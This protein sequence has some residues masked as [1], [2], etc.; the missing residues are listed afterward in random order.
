MT[1]KKDIRI[2]SNV[3]DDI[4]LKAPNRA[5]MRAVGFTDESFKKPQIGVVSNWAETTPCNIH[6]NDL[7]QFA[8]EGFLKR[9]GYRFNLTQSLSQMVLQW[10]HRECVSHYRHVILLQIL[11]K[12]WFRDRTLIHSLQLADAIKT[13]QA[14]RLL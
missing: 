4:G 9:A 7:A 12:R 11:L 13:C 3:Y 14:V 8:K 5:M 2:R 10:G 1:E 6:L